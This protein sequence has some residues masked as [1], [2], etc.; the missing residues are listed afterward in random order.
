[1]TYGLCCTEVGL[2]LALEADG[3][4]R[5][6]WDG[7]V[8]ISATVLLVEDD[9]AVRECLHEVLDELGGQVNDAANAAEA[10]ERIAAEGVLDVLVTDLLLGPGPNGL[11]LIAAARQ[12]WPGMRAVL[13]SGTDVQD[14]ALDPG[15]RFLRKPFD[16]DTLTRTVS[17][18]I[19]GQD[20][21]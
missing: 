2:A 9:A 16:V 7:Q 11:A 20:R 14:P 21:P 1:M 12:R 5:V 6:R 3:P 8:P 17:E 19:A 15:D 13:I 10:L 4:S 18:L